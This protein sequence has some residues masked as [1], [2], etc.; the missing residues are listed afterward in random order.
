MPS[1][2]APP[3]LARIEYY[4]CNGCS[5]I[6]KDPEKFSK[7][8][9]CAESGLPTITE[10]ELEKRA[11][12]FAR[13]LNKGLN[14]LNKKCL[15][16]M[17]KEEKKRLREFDKELIKEFPHLHPDNRIPMLKELF[18]EY[19]AKHYVIVPG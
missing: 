19:M 2:G 16:E 6:F 9:S 8:K 4:I 11:E 13:E 18:C 5:V 12:R 3:K 1:V 14:E 7:E 17:T 10:S 15:T